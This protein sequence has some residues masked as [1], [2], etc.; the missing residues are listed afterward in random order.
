[1]A[2]ERGEQE[3]RELTGVARSQHLLY[4]LP[5]D[6][7]AIPQFLTPLLDRLDAT[8]PGTQLLVITPDVDLALDI[9][10]AVASGH[11]D[12]AQ[13]VA[14][15][16]VR[17]ATRLLRPPPAI[18]AGTPEDL[19][20]LLHAST[21]KIDAL[22]TVVF[23]WIDS[24]LAS[25]GEGAIGS[26]LGEVPRDAARILVS[27]ELTPAVEDFV[28]RHARRARR[29]GDTAVGMGESVDLRYLAV[30]AGAR[31]RTLRRLLD[32]EDPEQAALY[33]RT[34]D[35][36]ADVERL[37]RALGHGSGGGVHVTRGDAAAG[38]TLILYQLPPSREALRTLAEG[39]S[40]IIALVQPRQLGALRALAG[41][42]QVV[43][44]Q[45]PEA[46]AGARRREE[47][48]REELRQVL[49]DGAPAR[50]LLAL[51]PL[52]DEFDG[53]EIAAAALALLERARSA[54]TTGAATSA[55]PAA[56]TVAPA[57]A[58]RSPAPAADAGA[59]VRL[60]ISAG[61]RDGVAARDL[62]GVIANEGGLTGEQ[63]GKIEV[64][65]SHSLVEVPASEAEEVGRRLTGAS[66]R[67]RRLQARVDSDR[68]RSRSPR[69]GQDERSRG[70]RDRDDRPRPPRNREDRSGAPKGREERP[71][72]PRGR[73]DRP[74]G[75]REGAREDRG[76]SGRSG[77]PRGRTGAAGGSRFEGRGRPDGGGSARRDDRARP[78]G[79]GKPEGRGRP[80]GRAR[81]ERRDRD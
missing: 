5:H 17:R 38:A 51:E 31:L 72:G 11:T 3:Q 68:P 67:G 57:G 69:E 30:S 60:F 37:L 45:L 81:P 8:R 66:L 65:D 41:G 39:A 44:V 27:S 52:L 42:G 50:E 6:A 20:D 22:T 12:G 29:I 63:V 28:E 14:V 36:A 70:P 55:S 40:Q 49:A 23:A 79:R 1:L 10:G 71:R 75:P 4:I 77:P 62:M 47:Q 76:G 73:D 54:G 15:T 58:R 9:A 53:S 80:E 43:P 59:T 19:L 34:D 13:A 16:S 64:R 32:A 33:V 74:R 78:A 25:R 61:T 48:V 35:Q 21:L 26:L 46:A 18:I 7:A 24:L 2:Q 56:S